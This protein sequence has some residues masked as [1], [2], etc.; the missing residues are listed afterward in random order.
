MLVDPEA[1]VKDFAMTQIARCC[2]GCKDTDLLEVKWDRWEVC[3][4]GNWEW[5]K[6]ND[7]VLMGYSLRV[8]HWR[9]IV[10]VYWDSPTFSPLWDKGIAVDELYDHRDPRCNEKPNFDLCER[11]NVAK[12][13]SLQPVKDDLYKKI[14]EIADN[15]N[16]NAWEKWKSE[17]GK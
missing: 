6:Y 9:Y 10:W 2:S 13:E 15:N 17:K 14:R 5:D 4:G 7:K 11:S 12:E 1:K 3:K 8:E 16:M